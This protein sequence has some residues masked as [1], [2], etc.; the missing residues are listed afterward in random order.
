MR[1]AGIVLVALVV[2]TAARAQTPPGAEV[3]EQSDV[4]IPM[5]DGVKLHT[6]LFIPKNQ[7]TNLPFILTRTPF[8]IAGAAGNFA[9]SY[10]ELAEDGYIF[11][12]QDIRG[13]FTSE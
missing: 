3:F 10:A 1:R 5:R 6:K 8:G 2:A 7:T 13:R 9:T 4:M 12:F 11:V